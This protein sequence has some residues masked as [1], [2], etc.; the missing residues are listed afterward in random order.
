MEDVALFVASFHEY[1]RRSFP[2]S[3]NPA[4]IMEDTVR[5]IKAAR[6]LEAAFPMIREELLKARE[7]AGSAKPSN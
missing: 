4:N 7:G 3:F 1:P 6:K 5:T 2:P